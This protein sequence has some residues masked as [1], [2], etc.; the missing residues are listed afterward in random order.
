M[1]T[2]KTSRDSLAGTA[3]T[4]S[5]I[6]LEDNGYQKNLTGRQINMIAIGGS[7][8]TGLFLG[9]GERLESAG[10]SLVFSYAICGI[11]AFFILRALGE[12][13]L[14]RPTSG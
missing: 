1:K 4:D 6:E 5:V 14:H 10:P 3:K 11:F 9:A 2:S 13:I 7:I 8:G 12:L